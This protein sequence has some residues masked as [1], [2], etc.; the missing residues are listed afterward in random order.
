MVVIDFRRIPG[1]S[2]PWVLRHVRAGEAQTRAEIEDAGF[3]LVERL[4][5]MRTR[6]YLRF[7]KR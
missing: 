6:Y 1:T 3:A 7:R 5:F 4:D 2:G